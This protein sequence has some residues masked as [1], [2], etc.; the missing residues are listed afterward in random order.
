MRAPAKVNIGLRVLGV[1]PDGYHE[2]WTIL[3]E[4]DLADEILLWESPDLSLL[5]TPELPDVPSDES[6]LVIKAARI[7]RQATACRIGAKIHLRKNIPA[8]AG[9][10][11][12]SSDAAAVLRG[13]NLLW[14]TKLTNA[15]LAELASQIGSDVPF[16]IRGGC[17]LATGRGAILQSI[18]SRI[19][20]PVVLLCPDIGISTAW[21][22]KN[23]EKY[24]L[25]T[26]FEN[27]TFHDYIEKH[28]SDPAAP[29]CFINDFEPL[30]FD[31][32]PSLK[33]LKEALLQNGAYYASLS[34]TG[35]SLFGVFSSYSAASLASQGIKLN[36]KV[37]L[38]T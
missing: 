22:Y 11:G 3:Q 8:G 36:G 1:R 27:I 5:V 14:G 24:R 13:L 6:N 33:S 16:F 29:S 20:D 17:C 7:L 34:G 18:E 37:F 19:H 38:L 32:H 30:V 4:I 35:S 31:F 15:E 2:I 12:G 28:L 10:G 23:I 21:A 26:Q 25:T 9:L